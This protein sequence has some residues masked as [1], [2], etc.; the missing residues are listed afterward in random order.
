MIGGFEEP[1]EGRILLDGVDITSTP[2]HRRNVNTVF[3]SYALFPHLSLF[4][5]VAFG[6]K[7]RKMEKSKITSLVNEYL[8][9]VGL[10]GMGHRTTNQI[11]GGQ[12]QRVALA[13][14]LVNHPSVLLLDEPMG[15]LDAKIRHSMRVELKRIQREVGITFVYVTHDQEEA[16]SLGD[17]IAVMDAGRFAD[18]GDPR[19]VYDRPSTEFVAQFLGDCNF[20]PVTHSGSTTSLAGGAPLEISGYSDAQ[21]AAVDKVGVRPE[22]L[23]LS[24]PDAGAASTPNR[25][26]ARVATVVYLGATTEYGL[27][28]DWGG[29]LKAVAQST[30]GEL[31]L[32]PGDD[33]VAQWRSDHC[34]ALSTTAP[35]PA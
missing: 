11:S 23:Q 18:L 35:V 8:D 14:A 16:M 30:G 5:N 32:V 22:K 20:I 10:T 3:Q 21:L 34:F 24:A 2:A 27:E 6:L 26:S 13:R 29:A 9:L 12:Q 17:R 28:T 25:V 4:D 7:R 33:V 15:A 1:T 31:R 19:R